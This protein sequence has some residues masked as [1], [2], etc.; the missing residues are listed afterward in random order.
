[1]PPAKKAAS[2]AMRVRFSLPRAD[3]SSAQWL[4]SQASLSRS[5]QTLIR[6]SIEREGYTDVA[7]RP[8]RP[9][10]GPGDGGD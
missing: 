9:V 6:E 3:E 7:N 4:E 2:S 1:M 10:S 5:I 8:V